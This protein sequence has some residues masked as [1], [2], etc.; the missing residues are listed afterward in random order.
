MHTILIYSNV[1]MPRLD[2]NLN[3]LIGNILI[4]E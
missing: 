1:H 2:M 4:G 3:R